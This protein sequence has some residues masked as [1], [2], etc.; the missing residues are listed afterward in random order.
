MNYKFLLQI[1]KWLWTVVVI[2]FIVYYLISRW[3]Q[4]GEYLYSV[5]FS[6]LLLSVCFLIF[7]KLF[8]VFISQFSLRREREYLSYEVVF[9]IVMF[10]HLA[11]YLPGGVWHYV[12]RFSAYAGQNVVAKKTVKAMISENVW[13]LSGAVF[14]GTIAGVLSSQG[15]DL[16]QQ[17]GVFISAEF[18]V[19]VV[20]SVWFLILFI[21]GKLFRAEETISNTRVFFVQLLSWLFLG[22]SFAFVFPEF[23]SQKMLFY[24]SVYSFGWLAGYVA[25]FAPGGLG[26]REMTIIW[27]LSG[28]LEP[29]AAMM[30]STVH[31]FLFIIAE[32]I[33]GAVA[34]LLYLFRKCNW[35]KI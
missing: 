6:N 22:L 7:S 1:V 3:Q 11:K 28:A 31:R 8:L 29:D 24:V 13:L 27:L 19:L 25:V 32:L 17:Q 16:L 5:P 23:N 33:L 9:S 21:Y 34:G 26:I 35:K 20:V 2:V 14:T 12:G 4:V 15:Q 18:L 10:T 30:Y